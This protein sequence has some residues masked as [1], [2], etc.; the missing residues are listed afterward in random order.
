MNQSERRRSI[1]NHHLSTKVPVT[2]PEL[3]R[4][5]NVSEN[6]I[7]ADMI[8]LEVLNVAYCLNPNGKP[9]KWCAV[10]PTNK[11]TMSIELAYTLKQLAVTAKIALPAALFEQIQEVFDEANDSYLS[12][13]KSN[14]QSKVVRF[15][16]GTSQIDFA[17]HLH[18][19]NISAEVLESVKSAIFSEES[20]SIVSG[21]IE[22]TLTGL[23]V[24]EFDNKLI[25][26]GKREGFG[27]GVVRI[28][29]REITAA[30]VVP[31]FTDFHERRAA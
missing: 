1:E 24:R 17:K 23:V 7:K 21:N 4:V 14:H 10:K 22:Q 31:P 25:L 28:S 5:F 20:I 30:R 11:M 27:M 15:E 8:A 13:H 9:Q 12:K 3:S 16:R 2:I 26:E 6:T 19:G 29:L 18:L